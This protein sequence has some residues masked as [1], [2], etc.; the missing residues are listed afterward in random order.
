MGFAYRYNERSSN[1][2]W[3]Q[4]DE[5]VWTV[6]DDMHAAHMR[7]LVAKTYDFEDGDGNRKAA[8]FGASAW[9]ESMHDMLHTSRVDP[10]LVW[11][12]ELPPWDNVR[13][14]DYLLER[15]FIIDSTVPTD[16][17]KWASA[18]PMLGAIERAMNPG[19]EL[20]ETVVLVGP[21]DIGKTTL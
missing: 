5:K 16:L 1:E 21:R 12:N 10:F 2:E 14:L 19:A 20:H 15:L 3:C 18:A 8:K 4:V 13:R 17:L 11:V 6:E 9:R 7:G